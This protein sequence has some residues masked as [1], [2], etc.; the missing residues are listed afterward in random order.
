ME[1]W[2]LE[3]CSVGLGSG[4]KKFEV[5][6]CRVPGLGLCSSICDLGFRDGGLVLGLGFRV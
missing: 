3:I 5:Q 4:M 2:G 6:R 1:V